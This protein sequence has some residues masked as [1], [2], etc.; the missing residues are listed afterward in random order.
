MTC[1]DPWR[2]CAEEMGLLDRL[3][4]R[5]GASRGIRQASV[6]L[7]VTTRCNLRCRYCYNVWNGRDY[8]RG[9]LDTPSMR[10]LVSR[11]CGQTGC[12]LLTFTGGEPLLRGD[13]E[14]LVRHARKEGVGVNLITNGI[15]L[16]P[17]RTA[18]LVDAGVGLFE[19][20]LLGSERRLAMDLHGDDALSAT[21]EA[22]LLIRE[23]GGE[24]VTAFV[25]TALNIHQAL[26]AAE[27]S[28][29]LGA[30]GMMFNRFNPG[31]RG[32]R[33]ADALMPPPDALAVALEALNGFS[34]DTGFPVSCS[35]P[36][37]PC[38]LDVSPYRNLSFGFC[39]A[40]TPRAYYTVDPMGNL[41]MCNHSPGILGDLNSEDFAVLTAQDRIAPFIDPVPEDCI[42]CARLSDCRCGCRAG[43]ESCYGTLSLPDPYLRRF[44]TGPIMEDSP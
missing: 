40:A 10:R 5:S 43:A 32:C 3:R 36:I 30:A 39:A 27:I 22:I 23:A 4:R 8:P 33:D 15:L 2:R 44:G 37:H 26:D 31:G 11:I 6:I 7:E 28:F 17:A 38:I 1:S 21:Q 20:P 29:A 42:G 35:I 25:A 24:V 19:T 16:E 34:E 14:E 12:D 41:R 9:E 13:L 18:A